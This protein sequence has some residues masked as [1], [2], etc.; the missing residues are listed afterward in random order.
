MAMSGT[1]SCNN[2][3]WAIPKYLLITLG[4]W[5]ANFGVVDPWFARHLSS[6]RHFPTQRTTEVD[7]KYT[8]SA[9]KKRDKSRLSCCC[10]AQ[11]WLMSVRYCCCDM[12]ATSSMVMMMR[13]GH[14]KRPYSWTLVCCQPNG[15]LMLSFSNWFRQ[16]VQMYTSLKKKRFFA[17]QILTRSPRQSMWII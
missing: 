14:V 6:T 4:W 2:N 15:G 1:A 9:M 5:S 7:E 13:G 8:T 16:G 17:F 11:K 3:P 10:A 12:S